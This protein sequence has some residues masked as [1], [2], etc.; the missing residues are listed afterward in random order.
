MADLGWGVEESRT[1]GSSRIVVDKDL[2][3]IPGLER[4]CCFGLESSGRDDADEKLE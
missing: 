2:C 3:M 1:K 4:N